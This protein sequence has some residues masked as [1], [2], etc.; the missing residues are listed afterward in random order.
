MIW[1]Y[2]IL[3]SSSKTVWKHSNLLIWTP[4]ILETIQKVSFSNPLTFFLE[5]GPFPPCSSFHFFLD[6]PRAQSFSLCFLIF[7][8]KSGPTTRPSSSS[9]LPPQSHR[10]Q[11]PI[12]RPLLCRVLHVALLCIM[13]STVAP[14][15]FPPNWCHPVSPSPLTPTEKQ[16]V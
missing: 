13:K 6:F 15:S 16:R 10:R 3:K 1:I 9:C 8:S 2:P 7:I 12:G 4:K 14:S 11:T 5:F